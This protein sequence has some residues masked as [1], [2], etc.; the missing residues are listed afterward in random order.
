[1][2][3]CRISPGD[4]VSELYVWRNVG[5]GWTIE[6]AGTTTDAEGVSIA[7]RIYNG[8]IFY[9]PTLEGTIQKLDQL[10]Q[11]GYV[12]PAEKVFGRL[13]EELEIRNR[14][15]RNRAGVIFHDQPDSNPFME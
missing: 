7:P 6:V 12:F 9:E 1:M 11:L 15:A 5:G 2:S 3:Y 10:A 14:Q 4:P 13:R 8:T